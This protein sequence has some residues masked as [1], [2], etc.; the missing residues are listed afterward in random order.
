MRRTI[1][2]SRTPLQCCLS[3][4]PPNPQCV[5]VCLEGFNQLSGGGMG[6]KERKRCLE[7]GDGVGNTV[8]ISA[9][10]FLSTPF[11]NLIPREND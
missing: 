1:Q 7:N 10:T 2:D 11:R 9:G 3:A 8:L 5:E 4:I 6:E